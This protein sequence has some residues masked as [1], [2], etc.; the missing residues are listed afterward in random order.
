MQKIT[1]YTDV[2]ER[3][4]MDI[5]AEGNLENTG[6]FYPDMENKELAG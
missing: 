2:D 4:L 6:Y 5:Y 3:K 1:K